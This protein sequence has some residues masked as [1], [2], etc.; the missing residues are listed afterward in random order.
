M[1]NTKA[2]VY[3]LGANSNPNNIECSVPAKVN[4]EEIFFGPC[5]IKIRT[6]L[7]KYIGSKIDEDIYIIGLNRLDNTKCKIR[8]II[9]AGKL[10][11]VMTFETAYNK[12]ISDNKYNDIFYNEMS[13]MHVEP[14]YEANFVGYKKRG[15][16]HDDCWVNDL[17]SHHNK[18]YTKHINNIIKVKKGKS[19]K[20]V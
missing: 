4:K 2:Y 16:L 1:T 11:E 3:I 12:F 6:E 13:P 10:K 15:N 20:D 14:H 18:Q 5:K 19:Q 7:R 17:I 9:W 8:K